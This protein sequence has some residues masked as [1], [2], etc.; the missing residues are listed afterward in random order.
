M[1]AACSGSEE[2]VTQDVTDPVDEENITRE[3]LM[4]DIPIEF[5]NVGGSASVELTRGSANIGEVFQS[6]TM[7]IYCFAAKKINEVDAEDIKWSGNSTALGKILGLWLNNVKAH[8]SPIGNNEGIFVWENPEEKHYYPRKDWYAYKFVAYH[9]WTKYIALS[10]SGIAAYVKIDG[11][12]DVFAAIAEDPRVSVN[13]TTDEKA[14]SHQ[15]FDAIGIGN[16]EAGHKPYYNF[17][18]LTSRLKFKVKLSSECERELHVD[19][20]CFSSFPNIIRVELAK[21]VNGNIVDN[22]Y[23]TDFITYYGEWMPANLKNDLPKTT[24]QGEQVCVVN[25]DFWLREADD[26]SIGEKNANGEYKYVLN[27]ADYKDVGDCIMIPP[28]NKDHSKSTIGLKV[29]LADKY[30]N[31]YTTL[32]PINVPAPEK[33]PNDPND[34]GG[35]KAGMSYTIRVSM[36]GNIFFMDQTRGQITGKLDDFT[37]SGT[38]DVTDEPVSNNP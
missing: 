38:I 5:A 20:I 12:D 29:Y 4:G 16:I 10:A 32:N 15:Y 6:G 26:S 13:A 17:K 14:Y 9:P 19:S 8:M 24:Y 30:G 33:D 22:W 18:H 36:G 35:W 3:D 2:L 37:P 21:V 28:V 31:K 23:D 11:N 27:T 34:V 25:G 7:G 1:F